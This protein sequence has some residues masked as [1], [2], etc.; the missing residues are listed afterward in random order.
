M[1]ALFDHRNL[2]AR[3]VSHETRGQEGLAEVIMDSSDLKPN[4]NVSYKLRING[5][6]T[7]RLCYSGET[8]A[9]YVLKAYQATK[10]IGLLQTEACYLVEKPLVVEI[11]RFVRWSSQTARRM[12]RNAPTNTEAPINQLLR[13]FCS[14]RLVRSSAARRIIVIWSTHGIVTLYASPALACAERNPAMHHPTGPIKTAGAAFAAK[15]KP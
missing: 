1:V 15:A 2:S 12:R 3:Q 9:A 13:R 6:W 10:P 7:P 5:R 14:I 11:G 8:R 4:A